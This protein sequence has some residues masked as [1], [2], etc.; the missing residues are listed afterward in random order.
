MNCFLCAGIPQGSGDSSCASGLPAFCPFP[1]APVFRPPGRLTRGPAAEQPAWPQTWL[2]RPWTRGPGTQSR[3]LTPQPCSRRSGPEPP[4]S[5]I[6]GCT[7]S[8][9]RGALGCIIQNAEPVCVGGLPVLQGARQTSPCTS[10]A[11]ASPSRQLR[12]RSRGTLVVSVRKGFS[13]SEQHGGARTST[14]SRREG[15]RDGVI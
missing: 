5:V 8:R 14:R 7:Q 15:R 2:G 13:G 1:L 12:A 9:S 11:E 6:I 3:A 10:A 4:L